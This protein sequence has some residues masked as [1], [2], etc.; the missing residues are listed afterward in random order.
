VKADMGKKLSNARAMVALAPDD[1]ERH[2]A[3][4][5]AK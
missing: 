1:P 4:M 5:Q 2:H 3:R